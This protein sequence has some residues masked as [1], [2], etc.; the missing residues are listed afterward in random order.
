MDPIF[1]KQL[2]AALRCP[3]MYLDDE[4]IRVL[5]SIAN[6]FTWNSEYETK[7]RV[8]ATEIGHEIAATR[9]LAALEDRLSSLR[10]LAP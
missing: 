1:R 7:V 9:F 10:E 5:G 6:G 4:M 3:E 8:L 2:S